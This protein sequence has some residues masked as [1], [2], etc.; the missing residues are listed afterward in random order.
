MKNEILPIGS[1]IECENND[2]MICSYLLK[3]EKIN[4]DY[5]DYVCC[6]YPIGMTSEVILIKMENIDKVKFIGYQNQEFFNLKSKL[7][8]FEVQNG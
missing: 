3:K 2:L 5:Y 7:E 4:D 8:N 6:L 1:I